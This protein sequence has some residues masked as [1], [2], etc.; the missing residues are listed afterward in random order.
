MHLSVFSFSANPDILSFISV[1]VP[2][3]DLRGGHLLCFLDD[4]EGMLPN[5]ASDLI[6]FGKSSKRSTDSSMIGMY[7]NGLKS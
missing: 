1:L 5:E 4:G 6:T 7:G 3:E 2:D